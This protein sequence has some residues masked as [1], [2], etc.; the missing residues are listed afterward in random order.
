MKSIQERRIGLFWSIFCPSLFLLVIQLPQNLVPDF[1]SKNKFTNW[2]A[3]RFAVQSAALLVGRFSQ[4]LLI[5]PLGWLR[6]RRANT[7]DNKKRG[8]LQL[9]DISSSLLRPASTYYLL[10]SFLNFCCCSSIFRN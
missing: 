3:V 6:V 5:I 1:L 2:Q 4:S 8:G 7:Y 10:F 9:C